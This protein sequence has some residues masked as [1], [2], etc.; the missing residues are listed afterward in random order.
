MK[1]ATAEPWVSATKVP[2]STSTT[3]IGPSHHFFLSRMNDHSSDTNEIP[4]SRFCI[5][6]P[7]QLWTKVAIPARETRKCSTFATPRPIG[8]ATSRRF[9]TNVGGVET[10]VQDRAATSEV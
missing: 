6:V 4:A 8:R 1:G 3:K 5:M 2:N 7:P 9:A 10:Q